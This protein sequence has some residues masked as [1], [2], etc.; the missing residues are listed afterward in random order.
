MCSYL[1]VRARLYLY[2]FE[3]QLRDENEQ[4]MPPQLPQ[5]KSIWNFKYHQN[6]DGFVAHFAFGRYTLNLFMM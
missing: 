2:K 4:A 1:C 6:C 5:F 3:H